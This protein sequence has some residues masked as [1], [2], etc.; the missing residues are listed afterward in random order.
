MTR[1]AGVVVASVKAERVQM[2]VVSVTSSIPRPAT[3]NLTRRKP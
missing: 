2:G 1:E 3:L